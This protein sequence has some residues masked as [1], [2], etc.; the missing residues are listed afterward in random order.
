MK[1]HGVSNFKFIIVEECQVELD[2]YSREQFW[3]AEYDSLANGYNESSGGHGF[4]SG[5]NHPFFGKKLP[6]ST[7]IKMSEKQRGNRNPNYGKKHS[8]TTKTLMSSKRQ[9]LYDGCNNPNASL[10]VPEIKQIKLLIFDGID[11][12][13]IASMFKVQRRV[14]QK[15]RTKKTYKEN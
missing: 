1:K 4:L 12:I 13:K 7:R 10:T 2:A 5:N 3:I 8:V 14:I 15:I 11:D 6:E 9:G